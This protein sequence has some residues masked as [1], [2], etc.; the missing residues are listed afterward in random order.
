MDPRRLG[1]TLLLAAAAVWI[2][3]LAVY[4]VDDAFIVYRYA[5]N[6]ARG[7]GFVFNP[8][9]RVEGVTC[10]LWA[11][12]LAPAAALGMPL[13]RVAPVLTG[14]AGLAT[15]ALLPGLAARLDGR[16]RWDVYDL[17]AP[18]L[19]SMLPGFAVWSAGALETVPFALLVTAALRFQLEERERGGI[20]RSAAAIAASTLVRPEATLL[21]GALALD[22]LLPYPACSLRTRAGQ[23]V[24]W[25]AIVFAVFGAF[26]IFRR[27]YFGDWLPNTY[28]AKTGGGLVAQAAAGWRYMRAFLS[29]LVSASASPLPR[30]ALGGAIVAALLVW[31]LAGC[32]RRAAAL[33]LVT[34]GVAVVLEGGDWMT[35]YRFFVPGL[36]ALAALASAAG[37]A[38]WRTRRLVGLALALAGAAECVVWTAQT[39]EIRD[40]GRGLAVN[41]EGYRRAHLEIAAWLREHARPGDTVALMDVGMIGYANLDLRLVDISGLTD[42]EVARAPGEF[43]MKRYPPEAMLARAPRFF[44]LVPGYPIDTAIARHPEFAR[45]YRLVLQRNHRFNWSPPSQYVLHVFERVDAA[46][47]AG[48]APP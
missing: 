33:V 37:R 39:L 4:Q 43:L 38:A 40:G 46:A 22:R 13:P 32:R 30:S 42:R 28:Y 14:I 18:A 12:A 6:L 21:A 2:A 47:P 19:L 17:T 20:L 35:S 9:E 15:L 7:E 26:L 3:H 5:A 23:V 10:F 27:V 41:A 45:R 8:G 24:R 16:S 29:A 31:G 48:S 11:M 36:P 1:L 34:L 44:V 25:L